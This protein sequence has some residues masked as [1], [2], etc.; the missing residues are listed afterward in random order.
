[1]PKYCFVRTKRQSFTSHNSGGREVQDQG[2]LPADLV[3]GEAPLPGV[4]RTVFSLFLQWQREEQRAL[5]ALPLPIRA[6]ILL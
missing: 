5:V 1:M 2:L 3:P 6:L 4:Q